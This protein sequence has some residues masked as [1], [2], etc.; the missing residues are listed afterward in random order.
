[1][2]VRN[3]QVLGSVLHSAVPGA[4][5]PKSK[6]AKAVEPEP[7]VTPE[8]QS[9]TETD[10][11]D[12]V[13]DPPKPYDSKAEWVDYAVSKGAQRDEAEELTKADLIEMYGG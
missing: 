8:S 1:M 6:K 9:E 12:E 5:G 7:E 11:Q 4:S 10:E 13:V 2:F 3:G